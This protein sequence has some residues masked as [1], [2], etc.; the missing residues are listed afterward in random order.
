MELAP[1]QLTI[2]FMTYGVTDASCQV[3]KCFESLISQSQN[4]GTF[5]LV[6]RKFG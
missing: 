1:S 5:G 6:L 2:T 3:C 4:L